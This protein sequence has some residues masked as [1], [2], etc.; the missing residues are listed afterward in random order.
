MD[1]R[2]EKVDQIILEIQNEHALKEIITDLHEEWAD[3]HNTVADPSNFQEF[4]KE[5]RI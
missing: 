2:M 4:I 1:Q 5:L 3:D